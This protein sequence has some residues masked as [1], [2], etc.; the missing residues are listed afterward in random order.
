MSSDADFIALLTRIQTDLYKI[1]GLILMC[2]GTISSI[3]SLM[4]FTK[5]NL[6]KNPCAFYYIAVNIGNLFIIY[7]SFLSTT[8]QQGFNIDP[9]IYN[10]SFCRLR[11][12]TILLFDVLSPTYLIFAS[13]DRVLLT[14]QNAL[15][16]Q[17]STPRLASICILSITLFWSIGHTHLLLYTKI[18]Q[19]LP[20]YFVCYFQYGIYL[21]IISYYLVIIK[22]I[23][24]PLCM[25]IFGL[26]TVQNVRNVGRITL[27][28]NNL[29][30]A[31]A[32]PTGNLRSTHSKDRQLIR[33]LLIDISVYV[34]F[35]LMLSSVLMY[36]Q[37][38]QY[39]AKNRAQ[40][41]LASFLISISTFS[42]YIP[43]CIGY[44]K[45]Y[46]SY[47]IAGLAIQCCL[48]SLLEFPE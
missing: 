48:V 31:V 7:T 28:L 47:I 22:G 27:A 41:Y 10:L 34:I 5:K 4:V 45:Y 9:S 29:S 39:Q 25:L 14:S 37:I 26:W 24:I 6:R 1:G 40:T 35:S 18:M 38:T 23:C 8:M 13:I 2:L 43:S 30:I 32:V 42:A 16:R 33:I 19:P 44:L 11:F 21:T 12:Y 17:R 46:R 20:N 15:T 3:I 36:E